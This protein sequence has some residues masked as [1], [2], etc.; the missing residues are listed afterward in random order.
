MRRVI[1]LQVFKSDESDLFWKKVPKE[2][3]HYIG[4]KSTART[5]WVSITKRPYFKVVYRRHYC[6]E[7]CEILWGTSWRLGNL[8]EQQQQKMVQNFTARGRFKLEVP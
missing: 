1:P 2:N 3:V 8:F 6:S 5:Y 4:G 7:S